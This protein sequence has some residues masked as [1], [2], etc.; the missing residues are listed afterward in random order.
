M[1]IIQ[2]YFKEKTM[3]KKEISKVFFI[4][5]DLTSIEENIFFN[6]EFQ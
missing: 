4:I 1:L 6:I 5:S 3:F 2:D